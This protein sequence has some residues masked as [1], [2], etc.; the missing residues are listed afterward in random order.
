[1][2]PHFQDHYLS[3]RIRLIMKLRGEGITDTR[4]LSALE[5]TPREAFLPAMFADKAYEDI[6]L[7]IEAG[8]TISQPTVVAWMSAALSLHDRARVLEIGTGSG[9]Q[10][11]ILSQL[12]RRVYSMERHRV[13]LQRAQA[14]FEALDLSNIT[15]RVGDGTLGWPEAAPYDRILVTAAAAQVPA[16][17]L[18]Q[19]APEGVMVIPVG[20]A[21]SEQILLRIA[22]TEEGFDTQHLMNVRFVPLIEGKPPA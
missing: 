2:H 20:S 13:L 4:V 22:R 1:M 11:A 6:A 12:S 10:T 17:L 15:T 18:D 19:L 9:Y 8:Q 5:T 14:R 3:D 21:S 16:A 7:P